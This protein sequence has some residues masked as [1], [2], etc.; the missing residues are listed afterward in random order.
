MVKK[1]SHIINILI[2]SIVAT[3]PSLG[4]YLENFDLSIV[5]Q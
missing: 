2:T 1:N 4:A 3:K 5:T